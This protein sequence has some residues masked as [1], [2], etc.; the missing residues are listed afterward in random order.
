MNTTTHA[1][2]T[3]VDITMATTLPSSGG[4]I[5]VTPVV[6]VEAVLDISNTTNGTKN[7][8]HTTLLMFHK[9]LIASFCY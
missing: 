7:L 5:V 6:P 8:I 9:Q 1:V 4:K 2:P 3:N